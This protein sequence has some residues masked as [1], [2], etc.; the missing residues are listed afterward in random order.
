M[1]FAYLCLIKGIIVMS[2][3]NDW[4]SSCRVYRTCSAG[5]V[6]ILYGSKKAVCFALMEKQERLNRDQD[7]T[8]SECWNH[9]YNKT[10]IISTPCLINITKSKIFSVKLHHK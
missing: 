8:I 2:N 4:F 5:P 3:N 1:L 6:L 7:T 9:S 10:S